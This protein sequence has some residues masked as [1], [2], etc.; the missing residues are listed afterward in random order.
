MQVAFFNPDGAFGAVVMEIIDS[1]APSVTLAFSAC[2]AE[3]PSTSA[4][5]VSAWSSPKRNVS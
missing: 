1:C 2:I 5:L 4:R 3:R